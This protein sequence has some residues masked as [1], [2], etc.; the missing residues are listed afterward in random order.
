[1]VFPLLGG[2]S[3]GKETFASWA[4]KSIFH[5]KAGMPF[6]MLTFPVLIS[7]S[8]ASL[9]ASSNSIH[10]ARHQLKRRQR[11]LCNVAMCRIQ[12]RLMD[13]QTVL[14]WLILF[15]PCLVY[16]IESALRKLTL[17]M[18]V[19]KALSKS[20]NIFG[21]L[22][23]V[24][25]SWMFIPVT[26][27][28][29][30]GKL[31][32]WDSIKIINFHMWSG[33]IV[34]AGGIIHGIEHTIRYALQGGDVFKAFYLPPIG[35]WRNPQTYVPEICDKAQSDEDCS[36]YDHFL[37]TTGMAAVLGLILIGLSSLQKIRR[38]NFAT[39]AM[40]HYVL[41]P[42]TFIAIC[43]HYNKAILYASGSLL[44]Y[45]ASNFP[46]WI[47]NF[48]RRRYSG[49]QSNVKIIAVEKLECD[50]STSNLQRPCIALTMQASESAMR[51]Y[52]PGAFVYLSAPSIS[53][54]S[55]PF[56][57]NRV[58]GQ[59]NQ[60][61][62]IFRVR[63]PFTKALES[64]LFSRLV[65]T[66]PLVIDCE[67]NNSEEFQNQHLSTKYY[68]P[69]AIPRLYLDGYHGSGMLRSQISSHD[70]CVI[71]AAGIGITPY[72]SLLS[73]LISTNHEATYSTVSDGLMIQATQSTEEKQPKRIILHWICRDK[74]LIEYCQKEYMD[75]RNYNYDKAKQEGEQYMVKVTIHKTGGEDYDAGEK[76]VTTANTPRNDMVDTS[77]YGGVPFE[78]STFSATGNIFDNVR[79]F[80]TFSVI[81][82][83]GLMC[84]WW[85]F[86][87]QSKNEYIHR[88]YTL[89]AITL[90]GLI[91]GVLANI[92]WHFFSKRACENN[93][94]AI[95]YDS[96]SDN[97]SKDFS[98][99]ELST[100]KDQAHLSRADPVSVV[101]AEI[102]LHHSSM[103]LEISEG[104]PLIET[105]LEDL[106]IGES[107]ALFCCVP[108]NL[109]IQLRDGINRKSMF[110]ADGRYRNISIY[111]E[112][113]E[114]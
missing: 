86:N 104:R 37:P 82:W 111:E 114:K 16:V 21:L 60:I 41:A 80:I 25:L 22:S 38:E 18:S 23:V 79:C 68:P 100:Y 83:G 30:L 70:I 56:T 50:N 36:C 74:T 31:F 2:G 94:S 90:Y 45:L 49:Q 87:K 40:L 52:F 44:Y 72:L 73:E 62:I 47:E 51:Q 12:K 102:P 65:T 7:G 39:F 15:L 54:V 106:E 89:V 101:P 29:P 69:K 96:E 9:F 103:A 57:A 1:M 85:W 108:G 24:V 58:V 77:R 113:F 76:T 95:A 75:F 14:L 55:H 43:I 63:G 53:K 46:T 105:I 6:L 81:S 93:W 98:D 20:G 48:W 92:L 27:R 88:I 84:I 4:S 42:L 11:R 112:S 61:R 64:D 107:S 17:G 109:S 99:V 97:S 34:I 28:G 78:V 110:D 19:D 5:D 91:V 13:R 32:K 67:D 35:C 71:V 33:R 26:Q 59:A 3:W 66:A 10:H 8:V